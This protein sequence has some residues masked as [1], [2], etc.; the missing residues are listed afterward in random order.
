MP[1][2][3]VG[4]NKE[5]QVLAQIF[6]S[7]DPEFIAIYGRRRVGKTFLVREFFKGKGIYFEAVGEKDAS[8]QEQLENFT[9]SIE[10]VFSRDIPLKRPASWKEAFFYGRDKRVFI[11]QGH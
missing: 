4:R 2:I 6:R 1:L 11:K 5:K 7:G 10:A 8:Y 9:K 3:L